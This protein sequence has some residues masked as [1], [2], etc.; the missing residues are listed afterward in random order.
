MSDAPRDPDFHV[1]CAVLHKDAEGRTIPCPD[2]R[3]RHDPVPPMLSIRNE[4]N[5]PLVNVH[6][7]GTLEYGPGYAPDVAARCFWAAL[8]VH[9][10][11]WQSDAELVSLRQANARLRGLL[12]EVLRHFIHRT[13]PGA[14]CLQTGHVDVS[15]VERWREAVR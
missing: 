5:E 12:G 7:D 1:G 13:H 15:A 4:A 11:I 10:P 6:L 14:P 2:A 9:R 8:A 3:Q